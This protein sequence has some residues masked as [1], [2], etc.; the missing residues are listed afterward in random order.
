MYVYVCQ[1][2]KSKID[3]YTLTLTD[4]FICLYFFRILG[5]KTL[6]LAILVHF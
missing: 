5:G 6:P 4:L 1:I 3:E 2:N